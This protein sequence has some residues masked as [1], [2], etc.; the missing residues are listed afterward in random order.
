MLDAAVLVLCWGSHATV[1]VSQLQQDLPAKAPAA[2]A[3]GKHF[4]KQGF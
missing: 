1:L 3:L 2:K 4:L